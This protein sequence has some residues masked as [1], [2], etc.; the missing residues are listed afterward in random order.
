MPRPRKCR[1]VEGPPGHTRFAPEGCKAGRRHVSL[2]VDEYET[3]R[4]IDALKFT[5]QEAAKRMGVGRSTV[6]SIYDKAREK[7]AIALVN[8]YKIHIEGGDIEFSEANPKSKTEKGNG[9]QE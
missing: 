3:I 2:H 4:L 5:Q 7:I 8:G 6:Q 1:R 9:L